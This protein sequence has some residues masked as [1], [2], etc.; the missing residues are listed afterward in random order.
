MRLIGPEPG[1]IDVATIRRVLREIGWERSA[2]LVDQLAAAARDNELERRKAAERIWQ[3]EARIR[4][5]A[6]PA[7][8]DG[9]KYTGD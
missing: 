4:E 6:P 9:M 5:L 3:L 7:V 2:G 1:S 8:A